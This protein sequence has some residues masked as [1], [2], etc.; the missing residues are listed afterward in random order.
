MPN[1]VVRPPRPIGSRRLRAHRRQRCALVGIAIWSLV[2]G[3]P[4]RAEYLKIGSLTGANR[5]FSATAPITYNF[6]VTTAG[7]SAGLSVISVEFIVAKGSGVTAP[8]NFTVY[9]GFGATGTA[10]EFSGWL[11]SAADA[12]ALADRMDREL[13]GGR[14]PPSMRAAL[15]Q[16]LSAI[17]ATDRLGRA[18]T[19]AWL[20]VTSP[21][22]LVER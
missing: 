18:R 5:D 2:F 17:P 9:N 19:A 21:T 22:F 11:E 1:I 10:L 3:P 7:G 13:L 6:G 16:A 15:A 12:N 8:V 4:L 20:T 14:M